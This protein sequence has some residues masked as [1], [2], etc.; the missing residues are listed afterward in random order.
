VVSCTLTAECETLILEN[1]EVKICKRA[2]AILLKSGD[3]ILFSK[4]TIL[5]NPTGT[6]L[7]E[8]SK[9]KWIVDPYCTVVL[10]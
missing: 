9:I 4:T 2:T 8:I 1:S 6:F 5:K 3:T 7:G 10:V